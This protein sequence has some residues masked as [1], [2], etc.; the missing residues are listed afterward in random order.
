MLGV[1]VM[2]TG[3]PDSPTPDAIRPYLKQFLSD[4]N[5]IDLPPVLWQPIL[6][7]F[8]LP[9]RPKRTAPLYKGIW[10]PEGSPFLLK[11]QSL[12]EALEG[13]LGELA[14]EGVLAAE[15]GVRVAL[16]MRYGNPSAE[17]GLRNLRDAGVDTI[18][19][20]PLYPQKTRACAV[21]CFQEFDRAFER[22]FGM[23]PDAAVEPTANSEGIIDG[24]PPIPRTVRIDHYWDAPGYI[25]ALAGSVRRSWDYTPGSKLVVS[26]H[27]IP[28]SHIHAGDPYSIQTLGTLHALADELDIPHSDMCLTY[29]SRFDGRNW[30]GPMIEPVL[31]RLAQENV[32]NVAA[33]CPGF[34]V[35]N[36]ESMHE[37]GVLAAQHFKDE[38][39]RFG[40]EGAQF[41]YIP[42]L[43]DD[44]ALIDVLA[45]LI[46]AKISA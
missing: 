27:S 19:V 24:K 38:C 31:S 39:K 6:N 37:V 2:N 30:L 41:S 9:H 21:T 17:A 42:A 36:L 26:F 46:A 13:R 18:V 34:S 15:D 23:R 7:L 25:S 14:D 1:L 44:P 32:K 35:D 40:N 4:R 45:R 12:C 29:Q 16:G 28:L 20:L 43:E 8:I 33:I 3:T 5:L 11:S 22:V 10:T